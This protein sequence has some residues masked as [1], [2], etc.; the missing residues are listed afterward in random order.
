MRTLS[1]QRLC[2]SLPLSVCFCLRPW[3]LGLAGLAAAERERERVRSKEER[4]AA[5]GERTARRGR[6]GR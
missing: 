5:A 3:L 4:R 1:P 2:L 6:G